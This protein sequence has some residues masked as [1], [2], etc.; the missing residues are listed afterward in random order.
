MSHAGKLFQV[1]ERLHGG[2]YEGS[3]VGLAIV[4]RAVEAHG[5]RVMG[6]E[7]RPVRAR[8]LLRAAGRADGAGSGSMS[9]VSV[10][11]RLR[12]L[13]D[14]FRTPDIDPFSDWY[15]AYSD[16]PAV[17]YVEACV[18]DDPSVEHVDI[19]VAC[20]G[21]TAATATKPGCAPPCCATATPA[22]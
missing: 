22:S 12:R 11:L 1:F 2:E 8:L 21:Q 19:V 13:D 16:A 18:A 5:G 3:G 15:Q 6:R 20:R 7:L 14:V 9:S 17:E 4:R 10:R